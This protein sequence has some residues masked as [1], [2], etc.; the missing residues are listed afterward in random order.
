MINFNIP[1]REKIEAKYL[2]LDYNGTLAIDGSL[3]KGV[4]ELL[5]ELSE[6]LSVHIITADTFGEVKKEIEG[7][8]CQ[9]KILEGENQHQ[10]KAKFVEELGAMQTIAIGNGFNDSLMLKKAALGIVVLQREGAS[11]VTIQNADILCVSIIDALELL[12]N[13]L[14]IT[15]TLR[16]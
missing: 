6:K 2:V 3:I 15:A 11:C 8:N 9:I 7:V 5:N 4:K 13:T 1:G 12:K 10:Q 16:K 14:R